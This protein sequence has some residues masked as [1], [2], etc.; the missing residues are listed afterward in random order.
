MSCFGRRGLHFGSRSWVGLRNSG[1]DCMRCYVLNFVSFLFFISR[2]WVILDDV[3]VYLCLCGCLS[4][5][6]LSGCFFFFIVS[7]SPVSFGLVPSLVCLPLSSLLSRC[8][9]LSA[10]LSSPLA[11]RLPNV[12]ATPQFKY[13]M[14]PFHASISPG[15]VTTT[16]THRPS[17][18]PAL[19]TVTL[20]LSIA[21]RYDFT[22]NLWDVLV[23]GWHVEVDGVVVAKGD[24]LVPSSPPPPRRS[25]SD[26]EPGGATQ[27]QGGGD[28]S[29]FPAAAG[30]SGG[31]GAGRVTAAVL[32]FELPPS[33]RGG[34]EKECRLTLTGRLRAATAWAPAGHKVGHVQLELPRSPESGAAVR[35]V[36]ARRRHGL[37]F[38]VVFTGGGGGGEASADLGEYAFFFCRRDELVVLQESK[39]SH[40]FF[41]HVYTP[42]GWV[43]F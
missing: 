12:S 32:T 42:P 24:D 43:R 23:F 5:S 28:A 27:N 22:D 39:G 31:A 3:P 40:R 2:F 16:T 18:A 17:S 19:T 34:V 15:G 1:C 7:L 8:V 41:C 14:Q 25:D 13:L 4:F 6:C 26:R 29:G 37:Y 36:T 38:L 21:N 33:L 11:L 9:C 20:T 35:L 30:E 10:F